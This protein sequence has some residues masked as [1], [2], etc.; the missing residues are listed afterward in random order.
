M[1][2][3]I[4][5]FNFFVVV[6]IYVTVSPIRSTMLRL[7]DTWIKFIIIIIIIIV[8]VIIFFIYLFFYCCYYYYYYLNN[9]FAMHVCFLLDKP[10]LSVYWSAFDHT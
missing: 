6:V 5:L 9:H 2:V 1:Y 4:Y 10:I 8:V 7:Q 3:L